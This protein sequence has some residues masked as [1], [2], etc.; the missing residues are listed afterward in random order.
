MRLAE[1]SRQLLIVLAGILAGYRGDFGGQQ[2]G[3]QSVFV[4][5]PDAAVP[6]QETRPRA[7]LAAETATA[8]EESRREPL[9]ADRDFAQRP[10][11][12]CDDAVD[13]TAGDECLAD[14]RRLR[15]LR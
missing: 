4:G 14:H 1:L 13:Q 6:P 2:T 3:D 12:R 9:E 10:A 8:V 11:E 15:P 7:F 5:R